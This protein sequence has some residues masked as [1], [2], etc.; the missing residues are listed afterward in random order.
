MNIPATAKKAYETLL[1]SFEGKT[2]LYDE[3]MNWLWDNYP[4]FYNKLN[5]KEIAES[6]ALK[7]ETHF[8]VVD[9]DKKAVLT[10][11]PIY[12]SK[13]TVIAYICVLKDNYSIYKMMNEASIS[14][15]INNYFSKKGD[16]L[17]E[18]T[19][20][21]TEISEVIKKNTDSEH[22]DELL[23]R[24]NRVI[25]SLAKENEYLSATCFSAPKEAELNC[26]LTELFKAICKDAEQSFRTIKRK[27]NY[28]FDE[29]NYYI[30]KEYEPLLIAFMHLLRSHMILSPLKS[31]ID[32]SSEFESVSYTGGAF[33]VT[34]STKL[35]TREQPDKSVIISSEA[36]RDLAKK[37]ILN[38][39]AGEIIFSDTDKAMITTIKIP[40]QKKNRGNILNSRNSSYLNES[41]RP[42]HAYMM[43]IIEQE[44]NEN[45]LAK[46]KDA[47]KK[48]LAQ[49]NQ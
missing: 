32:I 35:K 23:A 18:L 24:Q 27:V 25:C 49:L 6:E 48:K 39:Y 12:K 44:I 46:M 26:N 22:L 29:K 41:F 11:I 9:G 42:L 45:E 33:C 17:K 40:V 5:F 3:E 31:P 30:S 7:E 16:S 37:V 19:A 28:T 36:Y 10:V 2:A 34:V 20:L 13:R 1:N 15:Y 38:D 14:D 8:P 47:Q 4:E 43:G 21:S